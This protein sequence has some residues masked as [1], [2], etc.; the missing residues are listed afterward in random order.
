MLGVNTLRPPEGLAS[1]LH[2]LGPPPPRDSPPGRCFMC[3]RSYSGSPSPTGTTFVI[4]SSVGYVQV[5]SPSA[6]AAN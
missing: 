1:G 3:L 2:R 6:D 5:A 4:I